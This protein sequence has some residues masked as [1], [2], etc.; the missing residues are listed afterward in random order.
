ML[1]QR[2]FKHVS[3]A[4]MFVHQQVRGWQMPHSPPAW[5]D[6]RVFSWRLEDLLHHL[7]CVEYFWKAGGYCVGCSLFM[8]ITCTHWTVS[9]AWRG[10]KKRSSKAKV[11]RFFWWQIVIQDLL[12]V[13]FCFK[14]SFAIFLVKVIFENSLWCRPQYLITIFYYSLHIVADNSNH[15]SANSYHF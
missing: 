3:P 11:L 8:V 4:Q 2:S 10:V 13:N 15:Q 5:V 6:A 12:I 14:I 9:S 7:L 1:A